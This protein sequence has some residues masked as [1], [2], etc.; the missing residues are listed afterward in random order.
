PQVEDAWADLALL[1]ERQKRSAETVETLKQ[2]LKALPD[3]QELALFLCGVQEDHKD[4]PAAEDTLKEA[5]SRGGGDEMRFQLAVVLDKRG[6]FPA[7][8]KE[9]KTLI[10]E[11]PKH[12]E[13]LNYLGYSWAERG[14]KL[15]QAE[16]LIRRALAV[17]P[18]NRYYLDSLGWTL[19]KQGRAKDALDPLTRAA[20]AV[21]DSSDADEA[22]VFDHLAAVQ[23][24][25][26][27][28]AAAGLS[29]K[30]AGEIRARA[31]RRPPDPDSDSDSGSSSNGKPAS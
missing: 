6:D 19:Y 30:K 29:L 9:L 8:E 15:K 17:D 13:A 14:E 5:L 16:G 7:A 23:K 22:V 27:Q 26:G 3:S 12:A 10:A 1:D 31:L 20:K 21:G 24:S 18:G 4:L 25:L 28:P 11:S 2:G